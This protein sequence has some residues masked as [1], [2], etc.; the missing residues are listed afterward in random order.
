MSAR[1]DGQYGIPNGTPR[2]TSRSA[3][4]AL[5]ALATMWIMRAHDE[6][7]HPN[8]TTDVHTLE[9][10][11]IMPMMLS[12]GGVTVFGESLMIR[13]LVALACI[14]A[15]LGA[16]LATTGCDSQST[17]VSDSRGAGSE[18]RGTTV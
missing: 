7:E 6:S 3:C 18:R 17:G 14:P 13:I 16:I 4:A 1:K 2:Q 5:V 9:P 10:R 8:L 15:F 11:G 12:C